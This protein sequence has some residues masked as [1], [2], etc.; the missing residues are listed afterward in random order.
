MT[1]VRFPP[2]TLSTSTSQHLEDTASPEFPKFNL[3]IPSVYQGGYVTHVDI[4]LQ[5]AELW[6]LPSPGT[7]LSAYCATSHRCSTVW[8]VKSISQKEYTSLKVT[9]SG[10]L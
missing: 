4:V 5:N 3:H 9:V 10:W 1:A 2:A 6:L 7:S 8:E